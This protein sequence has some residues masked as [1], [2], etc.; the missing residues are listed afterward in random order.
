MHE[1]A[2]RRTPVRALVRNRA[3][4]P[5]LEALPNVELIEGDML[6]PETLARALRDVDRALLI[7]SSNSSM[8]ETQCSFIDTARKAGVRQIVKLSGKESNVGYNARNFRFAKMHE[9][10][11]RYLEASG[12]GWTHLRPSQFM[13]VY[14]REAAT[15]VNKDALL[16][17]LENVRLSP[18]DTE[19]IAK[20]AVA[21]LQSDGEEG[22]SYDITGPE[23]LSMA[24]VA[25]RISQAIGRTVRYINV[26]PAERRQALF[27]A[28]LPPELVDALDE[29]AS[30]RRRCP[31]SRVDISTHR[32]FGIPPTTFAE[33]AR[34]HAHVFRGDM[35]PT[36]VAAGNA[37][38][39][40]P[41]MP[42]VP[43]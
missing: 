24:E 15:I 2:R 40:N 10:I 6:Q 17:P 16:L 36:T 29:Q 22:K 34:R 19:D 11:E 12:L 39:Q 18:V 1:F 38:G 5:W 42:E 4:A 20:A 8:V 14:L 25:E 41:S 13:Q 32:A 33:F 26:T 9:E 3:K 43:A 7:S 23:A 35:L 31:E 28:G 30:E 37:D 21:I 27:G